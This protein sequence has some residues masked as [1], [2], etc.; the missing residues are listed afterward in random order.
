MQTDRAAEAEHLEHDHAEQKG[1][2]L[3]ERRRAFGHEEHLAAAARDGGRPDVGLDREPPPGRARGDVRD[4][5]VARRLAHP[6]VD[7]RAIAR[8]KAEVDVAPDIEPEGE[9]VHREG[10]IHEDDQDLSGSP[11]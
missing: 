7:P 8:R 5:R 2:R 11:S 3:V 6:Q 4:E 1:A 9:V 10:R